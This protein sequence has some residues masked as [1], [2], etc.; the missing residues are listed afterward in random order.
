M[1]L[2]VLK[3]DRPQGIVIWR[4]PSEFT[5]RPTVVIATGIR[6]ASGNVKTGK[7]V[8]VYILSDE[9]APLDAVKNPNLENTACGNCPHQQ[10]EDNGCYVN[11][12]HGPTM[13]WKAYERGLYPDMTDNPAGVVQALYH[14]R[15]RFGAYGDPAAV[16]FDVW[17][18]IVKIA[19]M[20]TGYTHA[21]RTTDQRFSGFLMASCDSLADKHLATSRGWRSFRVLTVGDATESS[22]FQCPADPNSDRGKRTTCEGCGACFGTKLGKHLNSKSVTVF[23][24]GPTKK[25]FRAA[26]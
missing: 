11:I 14:K 13:V 22:E 4:G 9:A 1:Q 3:K 20:W 16:P 12:G 25:R 21:W 2:K 18:P 10:T 17:K 8:Q 23:V 7:M 15:I 19:K 5:G 24:H 6:V 26:S